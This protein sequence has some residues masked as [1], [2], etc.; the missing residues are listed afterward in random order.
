MHYRLFDSHC[1]LNAAEFDSDREPLLQSAMSV[2]VSA[3]LVPAVTVP[4]WI[5]LLEFCQTHGQM[6]A[7]LGVHPWYVDTLPLQALDQ[8]PD[9]AATWSDQFIAIGETG[10]DRLKPH[11]ER[12][13][14]FFE[15][16]LA[17][18]STCKLP[19]IV[20]SVK[21][22]PEVLATIKRFPSTTG[23]IHGFSGSLQEAQ[24]FF[25]QGY[26]IGVGSV[27]TYDR[28][29]KTRKAVSLL[30]LEA[31]VIE[32]DAPAM[33]LSGYQGQRN[34]PEQLH[35]IFEQ[36][37]RLRNEPPQKIA[38]QLWENTQAALGITF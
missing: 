26:R 36:L 16:Q 3:W 20:H 7:A 28:A 13:V 12:Q 27:I 17:V 5:P 9:I 34:R 8:L 22:H 38:Q 29:Q 1:H 14:Q 11:W 33:P 10:L 37:C 32:T 24:A 4:E 21:A 2:G 25:A 15:A 31:L 30:P 19:V 23:I 35:V 18:A 6:F